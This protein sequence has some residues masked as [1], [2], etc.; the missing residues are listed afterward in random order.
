MI[1][2]AP[3]SAL[4]FAIV[5]VLGCAA[6]TQNGAAQWGVGIELQRVVFGG[7]SFDTTATGNGTSVRPGDAPTYGIRLDRRFGRWR[8]GLLVRYAQT[9]LV[10]QN[11]ELSFAER[12]DFALL[13]LAPELSYR[14]ATTRTGATAHL[15][16]G[17]VVGVWSLVDANPRLAPGVRGGLGGEFPLSGRL[18]VWLRAGGGLTRSVFVDQDLPPEL[19]RRATRRSE[20]ALGLRYGRGL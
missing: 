2:Q 12:G 1:K 9:A 17:P 13:E 16:L 6:L 19:V 20:I 3:L 5:T 7:S 11:K 8:A 10:A 15:Y 14:F 4:R 18:G